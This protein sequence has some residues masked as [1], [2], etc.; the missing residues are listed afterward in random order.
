L[1]WSY[2]CFFQYLFDFAQSHDIFESDIEVF[3]YGFSCDW[4]VAGLGFD[5]LL[6]DLL[7]LLGLDRPDV[8]VL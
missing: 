4:I 3:D 5:V 8:D 2:H 6:E 1:P 7:L